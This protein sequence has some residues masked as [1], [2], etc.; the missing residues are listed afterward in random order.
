MTSLQMYQ[1]WIGLGFALLLVLFLMFAFVRGQQLNGGQQTILR[2]LCALCAGFA[3]ALITGDA[4][5][6]LRTPLG[7]GGEML[8]SGTAGAALFFVVW[9]G[10]KPLVFPDAFHIK[11]PDGLPFRAAAETI[12]QKDGAVSDYVGF[13]PN[14]LA[15]PVQER[16]LRARDAAHAL[17]LLR[18]ITKTAGA[19]RSYTVTFNDSVYRLTVSG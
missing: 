12:V 10:I 2:V 19:V 14:E 4:L 1:L 6:K 18:N 3:G 13:Q 15:A 11:F 5:F 17:R 8:V 16:E 9:F 7:Q